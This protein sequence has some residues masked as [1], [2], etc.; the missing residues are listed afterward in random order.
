MVAVALIPLNETARLE[1][2]TSYGILDTAPDERFDLF[3]RLCTW[4]YHVPFAAINLVNAQRTFFKSLIGF[5]TYAPQRATSVCAHAV[6][7]GQPIMQVEDLTQDPR[8]HDH[9]LIAK[10]LRFYA[11]ALLRS[12]CGHALGTLCIADSRPRMLDA[13]EQH[14]LLELASGVGSMLDLHRSSLWLRR[15]ANE[16][17]LTGLANR[18]LFM[19]TLQATMATPD[20]AK[21]CVLLVLD[22]D[23]F[24]QINDTHGHA[25]GDA[26]LREVADRLKVAVRADDLVARLG[27]DEFA[28]LLQ[29]TSATDYAE[30]LSQRIMTAL[31]ERYE[32]EGVS[33]RV[34]ISIGIAVCGAD[35]RSLD[36]A[37]L[38]RCA[39]Q[40]LYQAKN[41]GRGRYVVYHPP[42]EM[43]LLPSAPPL[44]PRDLAVPNVETA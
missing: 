9:P 18:R 2:L 39:D 36:T 31:S 13:H 8:F 34:G 27:G 21:P 33:L 6:G 42:A 35:T 14:M 24:K 37:G 44:E 30:Q 28:I 12:P 5:E 38:M 41:A 17:A 10:G 1:A 23:G 4:I 11:G 7:L 32:F 29:T 15:V 19:Q 40:A 20:I 25:A 26:V 22:L 3:T 43:A 16:D